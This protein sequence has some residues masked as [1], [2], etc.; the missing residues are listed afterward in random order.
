MFAVVVVVSVMFV[1][2]VAHEMGHLLSARYLGVSVSQFGIGLGPKLFGFRRSRDGCKGEVE[3]SL[4]AIPI[5]GFVRI[6][7][8]FA[9]MQDRERKALL[10]S[11]RTEEECSRLLDYDRLFCNRS[12]WE[13]AFVISAGVVV[14]IVFSLVTLVLTLWCWGDPSKFQSEGEQR[15]ESAILTNDNAQAENRLSLWE[16]TVEACS[17][18]KDASVEMVSALQEPVK[19]VASPIRVVQ[20]TEKVVQR[21]MPPGLLWLMTFASFNFCVAFCN[22][23]PIPVLDGGHL[24]YAIFKGISGVPIPVVIQVVTSLIGFVLISGLMVF[25]L[26]RDTLALFR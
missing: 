20:E 23:L 15:V 6:H 4:H 3:W 18:V 12:G 11:G 25:A 7:G 9:G 10:S 21:Q 8:M 2:I 19:N 26:V 16:A 22:I 13:Q 5:G 14:N 24:V 1:T 17:M